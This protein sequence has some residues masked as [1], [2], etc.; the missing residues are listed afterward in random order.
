MQRYQ[1]EHKRLEV[2]NEVIEH[3]Q[4]FWIR[5][6]CN[7][8]QGTDLCGLLTALSHQHCPSF[9]DITGTYLERNVFVAQ[10]DL[11]FLPSVLVL[12]RPSR[13][14]FPVSRQLT[15]SEQPPFR[16]LL[17]DLALFHDALYFLYQKCANA[18]CSILSLSRKILRA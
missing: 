14:I 8:D 12:L 9:P 13:I 18:H 16:P 4:S 2:L 1:G 11:Q 5:G 17:H 7:V 15:V 10:P 3:S 6:L